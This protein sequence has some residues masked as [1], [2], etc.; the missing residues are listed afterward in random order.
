MLGTG[1]SFSCLATTGTSR[2]R[3]VLPLTLLPRFVSLSLSLSFVSRV[4]TCLTRRNRL[5][6]VPVACPSLG[7]FHSPSTA[8]NLHTTTTTDFSPQSESPPDPTRQATCLA[9][10]PP[11][12]HV[13]PLTTN[14]AFARFL[15][16]PW[17]KSHFAD[18]IPTSAVVTSWIQDQGA[19]DF[20]DGAA[21]GAGGG[22]WDDSGDP[23]GA[24]T[25]IDPQHVS[26][27]DGPDVTCRK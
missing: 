26:K 9:G 12:L 5:V 19:Q 2:S 21:K 17:K 8:D 4:R 25:G 7:L 20:T 18:L 1:L 22:G 11:R 13:S 23:A 3:V 16:W 24:F 15:L 10:I 6:L 14:V 27:H